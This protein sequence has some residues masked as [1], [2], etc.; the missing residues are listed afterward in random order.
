MTT[1][2]RVPGTALGF[3]LGAFFPRTIMAQITEVRVSAPAT[4][5]E[6]A[7]AR[8]RRRQLTTDGRLMII[9]ADHPAH[10][11]TR[12]GAN[13]LAMANRHQFLGRILRVLVSP[14]IDGLLATP[15]VIEDLLIVDALLVQNGA[16]ALL[17]HK[18]LVGTLNNAGLAGAIFELNSPI[19]AYTPRH[20]VE[21]RLD[22][23]KM[24]LRASLDYAETL[25]TLRATAEAVNA[26]TDAGVPTFL[27]PLPVIREDGAFKVQKRAD[28][29]ASLVGVAAALGGSSRHT[30]LKL[31][32]CEDFAVVAGASSLPILMLGGASLENPAPLLKE[33]ATGMAAGANVRGAMVGRNV[34]YPG[35]VDPQLVGRAISRIVHRGYSGEQ[36]LDFM[37]AAQAEHEEVLVSLH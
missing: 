24:L 37:R 29:L 4:I 5:V 14:E 22:G 31:P 2:T 30:W 19:T 33:F 1:G 23:A 13:P 9:A 7:R 28:L 11:D 16:P 12:V 36:A 10:H 18:V 6:M 34:L 15:D 8:A 25:P 35:T 27:E 26:L 32:Y 17:D 20:I 21:L 3:D